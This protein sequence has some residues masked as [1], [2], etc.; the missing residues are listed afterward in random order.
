MLFSHICFIVSDMEEAKKLWC[1]VLGFKIS[2]ETMLPDGDGPDKWFNQ[3]TLD[4]IF[5]VKD[6]KSKMAI[7]YNDKG[8]SIELQQPIN[9][10]PVKTPKA[11]L[12]YG[13]T[14]IHEFALDVKNI[15]EWYEKVKAAGYE[16]QTPYVWTTIG[17]SRSFLFYDF[18]GNMIQL[19]E[20]PSMN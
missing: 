12:Q 1:D 19:I 20:T 2:C 8:L 13:N 18:D 10:A 9:P 3:Q 5:H 11:D 6:S 15:D 16:M 7:L 17:G 14:G 4:D